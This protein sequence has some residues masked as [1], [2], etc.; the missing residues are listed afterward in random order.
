[1]ADSCAS[2]LAA[3]IDTLPHPQR[4]LLALLVDWELTLPDIARVL[5]IPLA[6]AAELQRDLFCT[7]LRALATRWP[8]ATTP[9]EGGGSPYADAATFP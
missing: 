2:V 3:V 4:V 8:T 1:M 9:P 7:V 5:D 6:L